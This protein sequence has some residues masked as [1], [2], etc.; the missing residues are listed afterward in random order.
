MSVDSTPKRTRGYYF[1]SIK[2]QKV[3][4]STNTTFFKE[5]YKKEYK[6]QNDE[7]GQAPPR[8]SIHVQAKT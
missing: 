2:E 1:Y 3:F 6:I 8:E 7:I 4:V 5:N